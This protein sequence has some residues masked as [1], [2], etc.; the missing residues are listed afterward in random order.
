M[1]AFD[2]LVKIVGNSVKIMSNRI[3]K[4]PL[5]LLVHRGVVGLESQ[6]VIA[7]PLGD[8]GGDGPLAAL[9]IDGRRRPFHVR[10]VPAAW[11]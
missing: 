2:L 4:E 6:H 9:R 8:L 1:V 11:E 7:A 5:D 3:V 10:A